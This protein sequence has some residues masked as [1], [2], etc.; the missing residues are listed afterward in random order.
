MM[1]ARAGAAAEEEAAAT[2]EFYRPDQLRPK[3]SQG[4]ALQ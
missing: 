2:E 3:Q 1:I 4:K